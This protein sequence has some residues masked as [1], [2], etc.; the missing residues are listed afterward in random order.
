MMLGR[1]HEG[2]SSFPEPWLP[3]RRRGDQSRRTGDR[4]DRYWRHRDHCRDHRRHPRHERSL[5]PRSQ[6]HRSRRQSDGERDHAG[7]WERDRQQCRSTDGDRRGRAGPVRARVSD[8]VRP[9][10]GLR[11]VNHFFPTAAVAAVGLIVILLFVSSFALAAAPRPPQTVAMQIS[12][13]ES[14]PTNLQID[15]NLTYTLSPD[16]PDQINGSL[17][18]TLYQNSTEQ[19]SLVCG[20]ATGTANRCG[21][22]RINISSDVPI[23]GRPGWVRA[24]V[25]FAFSPGVA[26]CTNFEPYYECGFNMTVWGSSNQESNPSCLLNV[27]IVTNGSQGQC[28]TNIL[29]PP[30]G[31][32]A[33]VFSVSNITEEGVIQARWPLSIDDENNTNGNLTYRLLVTSLTERGQPFSL[34]NQTDT[35]DTEDESGFRTH[36]LTSFGT[37]TFQATFQ[38]RA[39]DPLTKM[40]S[41]FTC[42]VTLDSGQLGQVNSCNGVSPYTGSSPIND[43]EPLFPMVDVAAYSTSLGLS[44]EEGKWLLGTIWILILA[45]IGAF[46]GLVADKASPCAG[47]PN[48]GA[49]ILWGMLGGVFIG[50]G[51]NGILGLYPWWLIVLIFTICLAA[52]VFTWKGSE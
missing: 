17:Q 13:V 51:S 46:L 23:T 24:P 1:V 30:S 16:D 25:T 33:K 28:G 44:L 6:L 18:Y 42:Q 45:G 2:K 21:W 52:I 50:T 37:G 22:L 10:Q 14:F 38:V 4:G 36:N 5:R 20:S 15:G 3:G 9:E 7:L 11:Q 34:Y 49:T 19:G 41:N 12:S 29:E 8:P 32:A 47:K 35:L 39:E 26:T 40:F 31:I 27:T 48:C 43:D